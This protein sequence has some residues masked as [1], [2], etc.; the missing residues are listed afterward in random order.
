MIS[1]TIS[2]HQRESEQL[3][4]ELAR[5]IFDKASSLLIVIDEQ[6]HIV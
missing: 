4:T 6:A 2:I 1:K 5:L 3:S